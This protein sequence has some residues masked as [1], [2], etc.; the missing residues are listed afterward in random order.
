MHYRT[1]LFCF[2]SFHSFVDSTI[3]ECSCA[4]SHGSSV[5]LND[6]TLLWSDTDFDFNET[7]VVFF[8]GSTASFGKTFYEPFFDSLMTAL[9]NGGDITTVT[10][11]NG[12]LII[13]PREEIS[14]ID[15]YENTMFMTMKS[16]IL[17]LNGF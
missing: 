16:L 7:V 15:A 13:T 12:K 2:I 8:V 17:V 11:E 14:F 10:C 9:L 1:F 4:F 6:G 3:D 5:S